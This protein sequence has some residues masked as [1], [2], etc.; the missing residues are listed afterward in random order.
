[1]FTYVSE[2]IM[3]LSKTNIRPKRVCLFVFTSQLNSGS[4]VG[5][6]P[7]NRNSSLALKWVSRAIELL[8]KSVIALFLFKYSY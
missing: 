6:S 2:S 4:T 3:S 8:C 1:M 5:E 7:F